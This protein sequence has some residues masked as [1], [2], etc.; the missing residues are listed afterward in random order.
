VSENSS[1]LGRSKSD[2]LSLYGNLPRKWGKNMDNFP[3]S[4]LHFLTLAS[5]L[6]YII[7]AS[8]QWYVNHWLL[9]K[10]EFRITL[11]TNIAVSNSVT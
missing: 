7:E 4:V 2:I 9:Q 3:F 11:L 10:V 6:L 5:M 1:E 8:T